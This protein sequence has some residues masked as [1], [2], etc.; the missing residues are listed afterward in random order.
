MASTCR[1]FKPHQLRPERCRNCFQDKS[2]H[3]QLAQ[4]QQQQILPT[5]PNPPGVSS[6]DNQHKYSSENSSKYAKLHDSGGGGGGISYSMRR[7]SSRENL[8]PTAIDDQSIDTLPDREKYSVSII[9]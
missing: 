1:D 6:N 4:Q 5:S 2:K 3:S 7:R 9:L 8:S